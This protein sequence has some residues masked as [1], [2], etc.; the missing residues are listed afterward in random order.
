MWRQRL[1]KTHLSFFAAIA[2]AASLILFG[3]L[4]SSLAEIAEVVGIGLVPIVGFALFPMIM[5][6]PQRRTLTVDEDGIRSSIGHREGTVA[7]SDISSIK[8]EEDSLII[9]RSNLNSFIVPARAF[10]TSDARREFCNFVESK[11][12]AKGS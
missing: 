12:S 11:V 6:K 4:P 9:Q 5:F 3:G 7:W 10:E 1:W 2:I 8:S